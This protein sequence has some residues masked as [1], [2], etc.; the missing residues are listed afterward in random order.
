VGSDTTKALQFALVGNDLS[1]LRSAGRDFEH[2][3]AKTPGFVDVG[4]TGLSDGTPFS[5]I[6]HVGGQ[7]AVQ[8]ESDL[9][10]T[11]LLG[12]ATDKVAT[13]GKKLVPQ[14]VALR[15][16]GSS[17]DVVT[18]FRNFA[19]SLALSVVAI[20]VVLVLLFRSW[21]DPLVITVSLPLS[22]V[23]ALFALWI[24]RSEFGLISL[25]GVI[26]LLGLVNKNAILLVDSIERLRSEG[27]ERREAILT[28]GSQRLRPI[29]MTTAATILGMLPIALGFGAGAELRA[30]MAISIIG[31]LVTSTLL[32]LIVVPVAYTLADDLSGRSK[33]APSRPAGAATRRTLPV[34]RRPL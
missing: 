32:S 31:G 34:A 11:L 20:V 33:P 29:A 22:I 28:A 18:T 13:L 1:T 4:A 24:T 23:G 17:A 2:V 27:L 9:V 15:F 16:A 5:A 26:F 6:E 7:R 19:L 3:L 21:I 14:G 10:P 12:D 8:I 25:M 30:P